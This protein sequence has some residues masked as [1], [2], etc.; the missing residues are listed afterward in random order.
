[1]VGDGIQPFFQEPNG[2]I[3]SFIGLYF[4]ASGFHVEICFAVSWGH[5]RSSYQRPNDSIRVVGFSQGV[6]MSLGQS[7]VIWPNFT[8]L[9]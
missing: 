6:Y 1:M 4:H 3:N 7:L 2:L 9:E 5:L 8:G